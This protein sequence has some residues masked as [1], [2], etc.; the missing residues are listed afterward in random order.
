M[1]TKDVLKITGICA[2]LIILGII[3]GMFIGHEIAKPENIVTVVKDTA[4][5]VVEHPVE[6]LTVP[7][8]NIVVTKKP[9]QIVKD[10]IVKVDFIKDSVICF[11]DKHDS[12]TCYNSSKT[13]STGTVIDVGLCGSGLPDPP[14]LDLRFDISVKEHAD[15]L[16]T[17]TIVQ[18]VPVKMPDKPI[19]RFF[20]AAGFIALGACVGVTGM[21]VFENVK[22]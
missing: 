20:R 5:V 14:P 9:K 17:V 18:K 3:I 4:I 11:I 2:G 1:Q 22:R 13:T 19:V 10:T 16:K 8:N 7:V 15:T 21:V 12:V 6:S